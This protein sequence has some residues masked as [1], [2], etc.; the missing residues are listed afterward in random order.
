[1]RLRFSEFEL[2]RGFLQLTKRELR[3]VDKTGFS[4]PMTLWGKQAESWAPDEPSPVVAF[5]GVKLGDYGGV[6]DVI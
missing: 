2:T 1:M 6:S 4:V 3:L 5:K